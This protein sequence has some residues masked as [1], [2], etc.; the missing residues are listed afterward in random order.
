[1]Y[2]LLSG[3]YKQYT[4]KE[5]FYVIILGLDNAGKTVLDILVFD[6]HYQ[7]P[8]LTRYRPKDITGTHKVPLHGHKRVIA[9]DIMEGVPVLMLANKQDMPSA[10]KVHEIQEIFNQIALKLSARDSKVLPV[11]ALEG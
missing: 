7:W 5:E 11:S 3:L 6:F 8:A 2:T 1:M 4:Q 10:L 9:N